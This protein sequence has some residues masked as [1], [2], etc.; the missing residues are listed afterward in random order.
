MQFLCM[1]STV[2]VDVQFGLKRDLQEIVNA[3]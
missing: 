1:Y 2:R 3:S